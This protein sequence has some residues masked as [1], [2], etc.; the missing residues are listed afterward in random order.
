MHDIG[1]A[2]DTEVE[3]THVDL[4]VRFA[5]KYHEKPEVINAIAS[6][7]DDVPATSAI[8]TLVAAADAISAARPGARS[9]S[10]ENYVQRLKD[11][12]TIATDQ[13]GVA[14][15]FAI[16][17][18]REVRVIV[19]PTKVSDLQATVLAHDIKAQV[20]ER[21]DYPGH[22]KVTVIRETRSTDYAR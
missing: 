15:A 21:L 6:H 4:G 14:S 5:E 10:L 3:G 12:E 9:E 11:L 8:A 1:K 18:G 7:H 16:Q 19:E 20:E 17:A 22:V 2:I 13:Q